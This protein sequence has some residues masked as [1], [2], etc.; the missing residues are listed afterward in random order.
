MRWTKGAVEAL[1]ESMEA[2]MTGLLEDAN[3]LAIHARR[4]TVQGC[5]YV[6][7]VGGPSGPVTDKYRWPGR[8]LGGPDQIPS[9]E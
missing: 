3:L 6:L 7:K 5:R 2:Y 4:Y 8:N 1:H 9:T